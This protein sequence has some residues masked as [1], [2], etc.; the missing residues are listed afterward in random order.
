MESI[1]FELC[2]APNDPS[3]RSLGVMMKCGAVLIACRSWRVEPDIP[4]GTILL[5]IDR[6]ALAWAK[7]KLPEFDD[8][9]DLLD[10]IGRL[11]GEPF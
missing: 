1:T 6:L 8:V 3:D 4:F 10:D 11:L 2:S 5:A 9:Q 7:P